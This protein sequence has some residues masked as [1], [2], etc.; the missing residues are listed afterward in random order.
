MAY[1]FQGIGK[2]AKIFLPWDLS[3][4][5]YAMIL[6]SL[7]AIYA[8]KGGMMSVVITEFLQFIVLTIASIAVGIIAMMTRVARNPERL[9]PCRVGRISSSAGR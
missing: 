6:M 1:A 4:N 8:I 3:P 5:T 7:T 9:H 2:F